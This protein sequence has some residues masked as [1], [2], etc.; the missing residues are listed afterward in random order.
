MNRSEIL[1]EAKKCVCGQRERDYGSPEDNFTT[2]SR[3]WEAYLTATNPH[4][5]MPINI[6]PKD[7]AAMMAL[8]KVARIATGHSPDSFVD[9]AGYAA[10]AGEIDEHLMKITDTLVSLGQMNVD[11]R[12]EL[13][14]RG[15]DE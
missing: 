12:I 7:V 5:K 14:E 8:L 3:F 13:R 15:D 10:C 2:I 6:T 9:L 4:L 11:R 1:D